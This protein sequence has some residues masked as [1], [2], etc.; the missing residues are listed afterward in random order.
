MRSEGDYSV[1]FDIDEKT[2]GEIVSEVEGFLEAVRKAL[3]R[4]I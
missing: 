1:V 4:L 2:A 3:E